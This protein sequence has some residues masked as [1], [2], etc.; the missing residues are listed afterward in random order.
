LHNSE[1]FVMP[2]AD[3]ALLGL[4]GIPHYQVMS[5]VTHPI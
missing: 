3:D 4:L 2:V 5:G 1:F